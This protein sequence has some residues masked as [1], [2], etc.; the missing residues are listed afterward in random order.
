MKPARTAI[1]IEPQGTLLEALY[2]RK[3][4]LEQAMPGQAY[5]SHPP[6]CT[7]LFG[8]YGAPAEWLEGLSER[9]AA[10]PALDLE[11]DA[12]LQFP[13]DVQAGGGHT[14]AYRVRPTPAL[15]GLQQTVADCLAPFI[16]PSLNDHPLAGKEPF[17]RSLTK[18]GFPFVGTHWIPH[19]TIGSPIVAPEAPLLVRLMTVPVRHR[20]VVRILSVWL[21]TGD[22]HER[23]HEL[24]LAQAH[25]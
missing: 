2:D 5:C 22:R 14:V 16:Q 1:F 10:V 3:A 18:Y 8:D 19:F 21:V 15:A 9:V 23:I 11:T 20:F 13:G 24:A 6:H 25:I 17:A 4:W 12:W 7:L